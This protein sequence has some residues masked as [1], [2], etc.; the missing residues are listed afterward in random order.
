M[1]FLGVDMQ[2]K[3]AAAREFIREFGISYPNGRDPNNRIAIDY[4]VYGIPETFFI[5]KDGRITYKHIGALGWE[6]I[7]AKRERRPAASPAPK[8]RARTTRPSPFGD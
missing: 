8:G 5:D 6:T 3:E 2:D 7:A 1:V 4:G